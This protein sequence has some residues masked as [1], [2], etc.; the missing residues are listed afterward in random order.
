MNAYLDSM[1]RYFGLK[2]RLS[3]S[4]Y[5]QFIAGVIALA[6]VGAMFDYGSGHR[7]F[8][9]GRPGLFALLV[10]GAHFLPFVAASV[11]RIHDSGQSGWLYWLIYIP[12]LG[13]IPFL[14]LMLAKGS[15]GSNQYG[16]P[17]VPD[18]AAR[19]MEFGSYG[20][21]PAHFEPMAVAPAATM[22][23]ARSVQRPAIP[24]LAALPVAGTGIIEQLERLA[25][26][27]ASGG[28]TDE[29]FTSLK[30]DLLTKA[31]RA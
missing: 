12:V 3:R 26:L 14:G 18:A 20:Q 8:T 16:P 27:K 13:W 24:L 1:R 7:L 19:P 4:G 17:W 25:A 23:T 22:A 31:S 21:V 15:D 29:E 11:R 10:L 6:F 2:G 28:L 30:V 5:W 9:L